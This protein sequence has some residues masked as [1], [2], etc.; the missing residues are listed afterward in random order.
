MISKE[1]LS[2]VLKINQI[3]DIYTE[4][5]TLYFCE[6]NKGINIYELAHK[7]KMWALSKGYYL[8]AE[9]GINYKDNEMW[10]CFLNKDMNDG[11]SFVD[12]WNISEI[13]AIFKA[14]EWLLE[15]KC[16]KQ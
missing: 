10:S 16:G 12:Y 14:C 1:L 4:D 11:A 9:Q 15:N 3:D 2:E 5:N 7:C 8:R 13:E 6:L